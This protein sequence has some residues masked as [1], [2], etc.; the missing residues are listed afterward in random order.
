MKNDFKDKD[1]Q[2]LIGNLLRLGVLISML[3]V[4]VGFA[5]FLVQYRQNL[6][7]FETFNPTHTFKLKHFI[8]NLKSF[9][10]TAIITLGVMC[11]VATPVLRV[12]FS[13]IG[14]WIEKDKHYVVIS[15]IVLAIIFIS[16]LLGAAG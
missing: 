16:I 3:I 15:T 7:D 1:L 5:L 11:L 13:I 8:A 14:F 2:Y 10:S 9:Q 6:T 4:T 12:V